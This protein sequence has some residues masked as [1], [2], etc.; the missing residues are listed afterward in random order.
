M[1]A[2]MDVLD[3]EQQLWGRVAGV[4]EA[5]RGPAAGPVVAA[6][7]VFRGDVPDGVGDSKALSLK[8][9]EALFDE[10]YACA[11][12]GIGLAEPFEIDAD[13]LLVA[14]LRAMARALSALKSVPEQALIDGNKVPDGDWPMHAVIGGDGL[15]PSIGAASIVAKVTRD[16]LM[17][18]ADRRWPGY[19]F[20]R[21]S[22]YLTP[23]H[24]AALVRLGPCPIHRR[25]FA[26]V[27]A[28]LAH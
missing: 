8:R 14:S 27:R 13:N 11:D 19:G 17:V 21:H 2:G 20:A 25:R 28:A 5:G 6:A 23:E 12:V 15:S 10:I 16:R 22:G 26:P 18:E 9:R 1:M 7:V 3:I 4:D 24:K